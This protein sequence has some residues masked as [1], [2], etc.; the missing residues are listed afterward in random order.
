MHEN[1]I[2][3][4]LHKIKSMQYIIVPGEGL[5]LQDAF[6]IQ[7]FISSIAFI[8]NVYNNVQL[9]YNNLCCHKLYILHIL[10]NTCSII[11]W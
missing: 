4:N 9:G 5:C 10:I 2:V 8:Q 1:K 11:L 6:K 7:S 3:K